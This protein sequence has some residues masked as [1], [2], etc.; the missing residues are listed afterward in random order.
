MGCLFEFLFEVVF[1]LLLELVGYVYIKLM[2][3][4]VPER[5]VTERTKEQIK[6]FVTIF[7]ALLAVVLIVGGILF[8]SGVGVLKT[9]GK[10]MTYVPLLI[11]GVQV[12][13]GVIL[14]IAD[15]RKPDDPE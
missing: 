15:K 11:M 7:S 13:T 5:S 14:K 2:T 9:V 12:L 1:E 6:R 4:I 8:L 10:Y 3:L